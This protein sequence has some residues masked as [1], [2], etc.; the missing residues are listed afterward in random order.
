MLDTNNQ[1]HYLSGTM[2]KGGFR[3]YLDDDDKEIVLNAL[4]QNGKI[5][6]YLKH[7]KYTTSTYNFTIETSNFSLL[8]KKLN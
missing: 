4:K 8:Y 7:S 6:F 2:Y 1:K 5:S 3:I